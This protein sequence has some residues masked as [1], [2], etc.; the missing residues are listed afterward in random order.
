MAEI[1]YQLLLKEF[2]PD[3]LTDQTSAHDPLNGYIP[4]GYDMKQAEE[5][6]KSNP[7]EYTKK[8]KASMASRAQSFLVNAGIATRIQSR[9]ATASEALG[10]STP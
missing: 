10:A 3:L 8:S 5:L 9:S 7:E 1:I 2:V 4:E 6:R